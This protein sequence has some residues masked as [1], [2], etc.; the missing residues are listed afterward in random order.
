VDA[1]ERWR[2]DRTEE[3]LLVPASADRLV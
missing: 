2:F 1:H 3:M